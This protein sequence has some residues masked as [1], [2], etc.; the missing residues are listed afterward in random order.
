MKVEASKVTKIKITGVNRLDPVHV[1]L[2]DI[3]KGKGRITITCYSKAWSSYWGGIGD[4]SISEFF[5]SCN[6]NYLTE[7]L[8]PDLDSTIYDIDKIRL[9]AE[10]KNMDCYRDDPWNDF[11]FMVKMY[12]NDQYN[13]DD[14]LPKTT[15]HKYYYLCRIIKAVKDGLN[16][17]NKALSNEKPASQN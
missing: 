5:C 13:W 17:I 11:E 8:A 15:N 14:S 3:E 16:D 7:N 1:F 2:E 4:K 10:N 6:D 12:G 9:D